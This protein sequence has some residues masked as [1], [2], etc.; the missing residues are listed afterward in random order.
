MKEFYGSDSNELHRTEMTPRIMKVSFYGA[1][2]EVGRSCLMVSAGD[3]NI[4]LD[5]GLGNVNEQ[6]GSEMRMPEITDET[7][8]SIDAIVVTHAHLDHCCF[9]AHAYA[10]GF[11]G[12]VYATKPTVELM[13]LQVA[14]YVRISKPKEITGG[15]L[16]KL[17][18]SYVYSE[19]R[20]PIF[21]KGVKVE[22]INAGH[23][24][25]SAMIRLSYGGKSLLYTGDM[26]LQSSLVLNGA[27]MNGIYA[28]TL[29]M[30]STYG[31]D[32]DVFGGRE[33]R[34]ADMVKSINE[35]ILQGGKVIIPSFGIGRS[36]EVLMLLHNAMERGQLQRTP[37]YVDGAIGKIMK[38][39]RQNLRYCRKDVRSAMQSDKNFEFVG[40]RDRNRI[41]RGGSCIVVTTSGMMKGGPVVF[42]LRKLAGDPNNKLIIV[43]YQAEG[44]PGRLI[45]DGAKEVELDGKMLQIRLKIEQHRIMAHSDRLMLGRTPEMIKGVRKIFLVHGDIEK[46]RS[47][48][49]HMAP[50]YA[51]VVPKIGETYT[52]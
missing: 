1:A 48:G 6:E 11:S 2:E 51:T 42:Y 21:I 50:R 43:G 34:A 45:R 52:A 3:A 23:I 27:D 40:K 47:L 36:Q 7:L 33:A 49:T 32:A 9:V 5:A 18:G 15:V 26:N 37:I 39:H 17:S 13:K 38:I 30:E 20:K 8:S 29:I 19:Y 24:L 22:F 4:L 41:A 16:K 46:Q 44:T 10:R 14:D 35:T 25:G 31:G 12:K 28:D